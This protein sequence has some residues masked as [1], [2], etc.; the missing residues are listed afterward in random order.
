MSK[1]PKRSMGITNP[2][3][4]YLLLLFLFTTGLISTMA[5]HFAYGQKRAELLADL[6]KQLLRIAEEY[7]NITDNFWAIY[8]PIYEE[9]DDTRALT[10]YFKNVQ[11]NEDLLPVERFRLTEALSHMAARNEK[12]QWIAIYSPQRKRNYIFVQ[13]LDTLVPLPEDFPYQERLS[14]KKRKMEI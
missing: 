11:G 2:F 6:D 12:V 14:N 9:R 4:I 8:L 7:K 5:C 3:I 1:R 13:S 10:D